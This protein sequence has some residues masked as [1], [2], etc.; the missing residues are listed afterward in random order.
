MAD[1]KVGT[2]KG[3]ITFVD[4]KGNYYA[5]AETWYYNLK[6]DQ[7]GKIVEG[8]IG[9]KQE[10]P[11][12]GIGDQVT[13]DK[14]LDAKDKI[15]F[16]NMRLVEGTTSS[17]KSVSKTSTPSNS[18]PVR[19]VNTPEDLKA[20]AKQVAY[21][22]AIELLK[23]IEPMDVGKGNDY[24]IANRFTDWLILHGA[25]DEQKSMMASKALR[26]GLQALHIPPI[27]GEE[28]KATDKILSKSLEIFLYF[29]TP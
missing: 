6:I 24:V 11:R 12:F 18:E 29:T 5:K 22:C 7:D 2:H 27:C 20:E 16:S 1:Y 14:G 19:K 21:E 23:N 4:E 10:T 3:A 8:S 28:K 13:F 26:M 17:V 9:W 15:K 25:G